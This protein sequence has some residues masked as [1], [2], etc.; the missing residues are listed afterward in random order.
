VIFAQ[1]FSLEN[2]N[3]LISRRNEM[4]GIS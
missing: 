3:R 4:L 2:W 1:L